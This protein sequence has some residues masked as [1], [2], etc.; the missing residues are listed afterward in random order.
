MSE[1]GGVSR[2]MAGR[3]AFRQLLKLGILLSL[4]L[5]VVLIFHNK[6]SYKVT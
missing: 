6:K 4:L 5:Y 3:V 1:M 2:S